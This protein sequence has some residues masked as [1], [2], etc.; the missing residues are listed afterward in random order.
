MGPMVAVV[1]QLL[2][3][4]IVAMF[5][6]HASRRALWC[7]TGQAKLLISG[8][9]GMGFWC[10]QVAKAMFPNAKIFVASSGV[11]TSV[12]PAVRQHDV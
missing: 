8:A 2:L 7:A 11:R 12:W 3:L 10:I 6:R 1:L 9:G 4:N 5:K